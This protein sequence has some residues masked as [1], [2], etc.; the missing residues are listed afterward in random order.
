VIGHLDPQRSDFAATG[1][2]RMS[3][4]RWDLAF[5]SGM[6]IPGEN[7]SL[8]T[9]FLGTNFPGTMQ[10][11]VWLIQVGGL[12]H[13]DIVKNKIMC[14]NLM[15]NGLDFNNCYAFNFNAFNFHV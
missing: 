13:C 10:D 9:I 15:D 14:K 12:I 5:S 7:F 4:Q 6:N 3:C 8:E 11:G 2:H 1:S